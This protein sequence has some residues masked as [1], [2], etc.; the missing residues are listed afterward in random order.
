MLGGEALKYRAQ[1]AADRELDGG[2][3]R[4]RILTLAL[5]FDWFVAWA[6]LLSSSVETESQ[7]EDNDF[8]NRQSSKVGTT[9]RSGS[10]GTWK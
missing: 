2:M 8:G 3:C 4:L 10:S 6:A 7:A 5:R 1:V 9:G